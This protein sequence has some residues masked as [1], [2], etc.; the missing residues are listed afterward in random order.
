MKAE[1]KNPVREAINSDTTIE[2]ILVLDGTKD[3][4]IR[5]I[6]TSAKAKGLRVEYARKEALDRLSETGHH[7]GI[8]AITTDYKYKELGQVLNKHGRK[9]FVILDGVQDPHNLGSVIRTAECFG[10]TGVIIPERGGALVNETVLRTSAGAVSHMDVVKVKN[11]NDAIKT[12]KENNVFV[13]VADMDGQPLKNT[14]LKGDVAIVVGAEGAGV[15]ALTRKL[16]DQIVS[17]P[18][19]GKVNSLNASVSAAVMMYEAFRQEN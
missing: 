6:I 11:I 9:F 16:A 7:Q 5:Q 2:K 19:V 8:I 14:N 15:S 3:S 10:V 12:L 17:I 18:M 4:D 13:Y 1:G